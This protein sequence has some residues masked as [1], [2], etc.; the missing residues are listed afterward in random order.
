MS[1][2]GPYAEAWVVGLSRYGQ[3][4][5]QGHGGSSEGVTFSEREKPAMTHQGRILV[6]QNKSFK[7]RKNTFMSF[8]SLL[9]VFKVIF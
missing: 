6:Q 9:H 3:S 8:Y 4:L 7:E 5:N 2:A 1:P